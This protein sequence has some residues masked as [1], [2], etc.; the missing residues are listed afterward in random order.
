MHNLSP[1]AALCKEI[2]EGGL[3]MQRSNA[4]VCSGK[5]YSVAFKSVGEVRVIG[6]NE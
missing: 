5:D 1:I 4:A 3:S 2:P 6:S